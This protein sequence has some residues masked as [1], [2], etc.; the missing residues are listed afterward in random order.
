MLANHIDLTNDLCAD[1]SFALARVIPTN[2]AVRDEELIKGRSPEP[3]LSELT[4]Q[5]CADEAAPEIFFPIFF[6]YEKEISP[7]V[8]PPH[9]SRPTVTRDAEGMI[10]I[11]PPRVKRVC[12]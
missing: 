2:R 9:R 1:T 11:S 8:S 7:M 6:R 5:T 4:L 3:E 10:P 12:A